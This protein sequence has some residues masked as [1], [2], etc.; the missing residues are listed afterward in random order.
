MGVGELY[1]GA[2]GSGEMDWGVCGEGVSSVIGVGGWE[3][4]QVCNVALNITSLCMNPPKENTR[5]CRPCSCWPV[6]VVTPV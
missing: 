1:C 4:I 6:S 3:V 5:V 2:D